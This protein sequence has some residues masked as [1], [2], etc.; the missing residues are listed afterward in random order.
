MGDVTARKAHNS[1]LDV[2]ELLDVG[3]IILAEYR[4]GDDLKVVTSRGRRIGIAPDG[5]FG[6]LSGPDF[7]YTPAR[8][9]NMAPA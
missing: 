1:R 7:P 5:W 2:L 8:P 4:D 6:V 9:A 3:E